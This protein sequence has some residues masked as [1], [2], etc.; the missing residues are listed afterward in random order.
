[1]KGRKEGR[2]KERKKEKDVLEC[3]QINRVK[4]IAI[5]FIVLGG[6]TLWHLQNFL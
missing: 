1:M 5:F 6:G 4:L 2:K 3:F